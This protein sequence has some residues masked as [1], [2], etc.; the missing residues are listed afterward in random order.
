[1]TV[2]FDEHKY[3]TEWCEKKTLFCKVGTHTSACLTDSKEV[4]TTVNQ[5]S[6]QQSNCR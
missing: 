3:L 1:M 5:T 2:V 4:G 6:Q